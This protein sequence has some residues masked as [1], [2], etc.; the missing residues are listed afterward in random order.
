M[1]VIRQRARILPLSLPR[2]NE[3]ED[4]GPNIPLKVLK[5]GSGRLRW[6]LA[7]RLIFYLVF[8]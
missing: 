3:V 1:D 5:R 7:L 6:W 8:L 4:L 2:Q